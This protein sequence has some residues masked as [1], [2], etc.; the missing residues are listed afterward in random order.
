MAD[1]LAALLL[2]AALKQSVA[3]PKIEIKQVSG[4]TKSQI[5][6]VAKA[7]MVGREK[8]TS[9][10]DLCQV[11]STVLTMQES[12]YNWICIASEDAGMVGYIGN[13]EGFMK[14]AYGKYCFIVGAT[15]K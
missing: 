12:D 9:L 8:V 11:V 15:K 2:L 13:C 7:A 6:L 3:Q 14:F 10:S 4:L 5:E 1:E